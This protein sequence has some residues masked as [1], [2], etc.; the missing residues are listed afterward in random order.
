MAFSVGNYWLQR[1]ISLKRH[2]R[3]CHYITDDI[4]KALPE[5]AQIKMGMLHLFIQHTSATIT[6]NESWDPS[7]KTD[8]EMILNR[9]VPE[10]LSYAHSCEGTDDMPGHAK[11]ALLGGPNI[12]IPISDGKLAL[13]T[14]QG[15]WLCEHRNSASSRSVVATV[16]GCPYENK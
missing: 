7:V 13:G 3:G 4:K 16:Q 2:S 1:T 8:M 10:T 5:I 14:W 11:H 6:V 12:T 15:I 9:L